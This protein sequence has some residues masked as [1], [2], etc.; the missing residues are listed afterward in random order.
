VVVSGSVMWVVVGWW[1]EGG[2]FG[3]WREERRG[4]LLGRVFFNWIV[5]R[6]FMCIFGRVVFV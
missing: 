6:A 4:G 1:G 5:R 3:Y 2:S